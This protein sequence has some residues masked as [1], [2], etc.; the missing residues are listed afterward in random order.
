MKQADK[1]ETRAS[2]FHAGIR[3]RDAKDIMVS[4]K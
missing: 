3:V 4:F 2:G 1:A